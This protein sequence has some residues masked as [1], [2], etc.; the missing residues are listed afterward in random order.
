[1]TEAQLR[2]YNKAR[3]VLTPILTKKFNLSHEGAENFPLE[4]PG[5]IVGNHRSWIDPFFIALLCP[6][7]I[8]FMAA[9]FAFQMP[10]VAGLYRSWGAL[11]LPLGGGDAAKRTLE[12]GIQILKGGNLLGIFPEGVDTMLEP[13]R[14]KKVG[15]FH[16]GFARMALEAKAPIIPC[17]VTGIGEYVIWRVS[18]AI[19]K[20]FAPDEKLKG[21]VNMF[22]Y[23]RVVV[24]IGKPVYADVYYDNINKETIDRVSSKVRRIITKLYEG[25][26]LFR[27]VYDSKPFNVHTDY[28]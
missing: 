13:D 27:F 7:P 8:H 10:I 2:A 26:D 17:S 28:V 4:G 16:T 23:K 3:R 18:P 14:W 6:R 11:S 9:S 25:E 15:R 19:T 24:R 22:W 5:L 21:G 20:R 1:M 12:K